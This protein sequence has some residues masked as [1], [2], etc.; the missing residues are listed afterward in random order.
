MEAL[1]W[2][3]QWASET[4]E[5]KMEKKKTSFRDHRELDSDARVRYLRNELQEAKK[6]EEPCIQATQR[7][8][9]KSTP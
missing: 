8:T 3:I 6:D 5:A 7:C 2:Q 4:A 9:K 1:L